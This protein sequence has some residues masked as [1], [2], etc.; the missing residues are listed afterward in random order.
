MH[1]L[2][3]NFKKVSNEFNWFKL[4]LTVTLFFVSQ[5][6]LNVLIVYLKS[7][8]FILDSQTILILN[9]AHNILTV[10]IVIAVYKWKI[11]NTK[12]INR[13]LS[14]FKEV[15][16]GLYWGLIV[17]AVNL[18]MGLIMYL[19]FSALGLEV[20]PQNATN[21][22]NKTN[23][24]NFILVFIAIVVA[25]PIAEEIIFRGVVY[26]TLANYFSTTIAILLSG[27]VFSLLH[28]DWFFILQIS[29][30]G[31]LLAYCYRKTQ[32]LITPIVAHMVV[33]FLYFLS[34]IQ[35]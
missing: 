20:A 17:L 21:I 11:V 3:H 33:N 32:T 6:T 14:F 26:K 7:A 12:I 35:T 24:D 22:I 18:I 9:I 23:K 5:I 31:I 1:K 10:A 13:S 27:I 16:K 29:V 8:Q 2:T 25:A 34:W 4:S 15:N 28:L 19:V 30:M